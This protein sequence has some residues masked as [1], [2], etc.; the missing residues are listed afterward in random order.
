[1]SNYYIVR[2]GQTLANLKGILQGHLNVPLSDHG[3]TQAR[4]VGE[5]LSKVKIDAVYSS[6]LDRAKETAVE[7]A[8]HHKCKLVLDRRLREVHCGTMQGKTMKECREVYT[9]FFEAIKANPGSIPRPGGG[10]SDNDLY[11]RAT[12]A[13]EDIQ[14]NCPGSNVAIVTHGGVVRCLLSYVQ[15]G[16]FD[17][18]L[19][20]VA[21][22]SISIISNRD[23]KWQLG[24]L[25]DVAH[26]APIGEDKLD[27]SRDFYRWKE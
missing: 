11:Q 4:L 24:K 22:T 18:G 15:K 7:I 5:A 21:N 26:L 12:R 10:E 6:D 8:R 16:Q 23:G 1:M 19:P 20:T 25:N 27:P 13:L 2:H 3:R 14:H 17:P 9:E